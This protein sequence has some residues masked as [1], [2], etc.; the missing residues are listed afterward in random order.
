MVGLLTWRCVVWFLRVA[1]CLSWEKW[2]INT[3]HRKISHELPLNTGAG[4]RPAPVSRRLSWEI[5]RWGAIIY[6]VSHERHLATRKNH[7][8]QRNVSILA[9]LVASGLVDAVEERD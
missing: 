3:P 9:D 5:L 1:R 2:Q 8:T 4:R 6:H 7:T